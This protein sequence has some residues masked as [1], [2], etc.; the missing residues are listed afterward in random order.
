MVFVDNKENLCYTLVMRNVL[1]YYISRNGIRFHHSLTQPGTFEGDAMNPEM[2][3]ECELTLLLSGEATYNVAGQ[4]FTLSKGDIFVTPPGQL[5][6]RTLSGDQPYER[7][8][9][10][11]DPTLLPQLQD[12]DVLAFI[13]RANEYMYVLPHDALQSSK[14]IE[15][16]YAVKK[17]CH[18]ENK[19][20]DL[21]LIAAIA[22]LAETLNDLASETINQRTLTLR[23]TKNNISYLC[24]QYVNEH[25]DE[26][27][28]AQSLSARL[29]M[30]ASHLQAMFKK[31]VG[32]SLH[33]YILTQKMHLAKKMLHQGIPAQT[34]A[35]KLGFEYYATFHQ[36]YRRICKG[37]PRTYS[38]IAHT[39]V[40]DTQL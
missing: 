7:M 31:E 10:H 37:A 22:T 33:K 15:Q 26:K 35:D 8:V 18:E 9:L 27:L 34:V 1:T 39:L 14:A 11:F 16:I 32:V 13:N 20:R 19:Y 25:L 29:N 2:H 17:I 12:L 3:E 24:I 38:K 6:W 21:R 5:H 30:S 28:T 40:T 4:S 36:A 23:S